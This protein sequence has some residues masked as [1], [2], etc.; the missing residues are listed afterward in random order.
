MSGINLFVTKLT[1]DHSALLEPWFQLELQSAEL[2]DEGEKWL[3]AVYHLAGSQLGKP[4]KWKIQAWLDTD[5]LSF[6][7]SL[8]YLLTAFEPADALD[9]IKKQFI[10]YENDL[11]LKRNRAASQ[12]MRDRIAAEAATPAAT[13]QGI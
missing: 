12:R 8:E 2:S 10:A 11:R 4:G 7:A 3:V 9:A 5:D 1:A 13:G 6:S